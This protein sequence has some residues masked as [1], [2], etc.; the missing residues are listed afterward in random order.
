MSVLVVTLNGGTLGAVG[1]A[2]YRRLADPIYDD[3]AFTLSAGWQ[4]FGNRLEISADR[5][6]LIPIFWRLEPTRLIVATSLAEIC[7]QASDVQADLS[8]LAVFLRL[9]YYLA[10]DTPIENV[11][12]LGPGA[13]VVVSPGTFGPSAFNYAT[14]LVRCANIQ[15]ATAV[16][17][18]ISMFRASMAQRGGHERVG[19]PLSGGRDSRH[20]LFELV[21]SGS[22]PSFAVT[23]GEH[24]YALDA[25]VAAEL[26]ARLAVPLYLSQPQAVGSL[27]A[28]LETN[29][30]THFLTDEHRW[31]AEVVATLRENGA[32][33]FFDGIGG[34]VLSNG[35]F[36]EEELHGVFRAGNPLAVADRMLQRLNN[37]DYLDHDLQRKLSFDVARE[38]VAVEARR[39]M[40][41]PN[42]VK[43]F[44]FWNR[45]RREIALAPL[46]L[47]AD[48]NV[49][50]P[51]LAPDLFEF[52]MSL[53]A[54]EFG[55]PGFHDEV[56]DAMYPVYR[57]T[58][59]AEHSH[60]G[61]R[62]S[63]LNRW[64]YVVLSVRA[65]AASLASATF[66]LPRLPRFLAAGSGRDLWWLTSLG[67]LYGLRRSARLSGL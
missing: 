50:M 64:R 19:L 12:V 20:I 66:L 15:R 28:E 26:C 46:V 22:P 24:Y 23:C 1:D 67:Y 42:P 13:Q 49:A 6:G 51:Y 65:A 57:G 34:D 47:G 62:P 52:L 32:E 38:R 43:S 55:Q 48:L 11:K 39:H 41:A 63:L 10:D 18:Y 4:W 9:G 30:R 29:R 25:A 44:M 35:L 36:F 3:Q 59:Y 37:L 56:I 21:Y 31:V 45:T 53:P 27:D 33:K 58:A 8:A 16:D 17:G 5:L 54:E 2:A 14:P 60:S 40:S 61:R 7:N